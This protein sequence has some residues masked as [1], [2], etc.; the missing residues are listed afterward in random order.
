[1]LKSKKNKNYLST[2]DNRGGWFPIIRESFIGA[3][4]QNVT[5]S[6]ECVLAF[7][8]VFSCVSLI[9]SDIA[10]LP[11]RLVEQDNDGIWN[12]IKNTLAPTLKN[13]NSYQ[14]RI[15]FFE[16]W[17]I[18]KLVKG[19]AYIWKERNASGKII[20]LYVLD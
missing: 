8:A 13:P 1:F 14:N 2:I 20:A 19:N 16:Q 10:K 4:Q 17:V 18:S 7:S 5:L 9:A 15:Q 3:W 11:I 12:E 6:R